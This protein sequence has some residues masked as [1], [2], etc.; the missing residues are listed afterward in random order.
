MPKNPSDDLEIN[1]D[2]WLRSRL[3]L[4]APVETIPPPVAA[5]PYV[6]VS[7]AATIP[8]LPEKAIRRKI[9]EGKWTSGRLT[10][11]LENFPRRFSHSPDHSEHDVRF[12]L[13]SGR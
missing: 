6:T 2:E 12:R 4:T 13:C 3:A 9:Q 11:A 10:C 7:L 5:A 8:G 1:F